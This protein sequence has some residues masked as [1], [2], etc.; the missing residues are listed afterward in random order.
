MGKWTSFKKAFGKKSNDQKYK[1]QRAE[2]WNMYQE[3]EDLIRPGGNIAN[4]PTKGRSDTKLLKGLEAKLGN[5]ENAGPL[6]NGVPADVNQG[7]KDMKGPLKEMKTLLRE[8]HQLENVVTAKGY[9]INNQ[10]IRGYADMDDNERNQ[11]LQELEARMDAGKAAVD[12]IFGKGGAAAPPNP[13]LKEVGEVMW[14]LRMKAEDLSEGSFKK[15]AMTVPDPDGKLRDWL[16][17]CGEVYIRDSS[18]LKEDNRKTGRANDQLA[19]GNAPRG[20][21]FYAG[22]KDGKAQQDSELPYGMNTLLYQAF[23]RDNDKRL[24]IKLETEGSF[25]EAEELTTKGRVKHDD[26]IDQ[27]SF[28]ASDIGDFVGH[29]TNYIT[30]KKEPNA[31]ARHGET[32]K[33]I[34]QAVKDQYKKI[35]DAI[36]NAPDLHDLM[37]D[38][39]DMISIKDDL[40]KKQKAKKKLGIKVDAKKKKLVGEV[41]QMMKN[42]DAVQDKLNKSY[43]D[44][45]IDDAHKDVIKTMLDEIVEW[46]GICTDVGYRLD[47]INVRVGDEVVMQPADF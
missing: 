18:H 22:R 11:A 4:H 9:V 16:D 44:P 7:V 8:A 32:A 20:M 47:R 1:D 39:A 35:Y 21:D 30:G 28:R 46:R 31:L 41:Q 40:T 29:A 24:Y 43:T 17:K 27:R 37:G 34:P 2:F 5:L 36:E 10:M 12:G 15:G 3:A 19:Q 6:R 13:G 42:L 14:Y 45:S 33:D 26:Q 25:F 23:E 38:I